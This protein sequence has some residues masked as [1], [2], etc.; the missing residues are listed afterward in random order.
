MKDFT[1]KV[2]R[3]N[4]QASEFVEIAEEL[5]AIQ[6]YSGQAPTS[7]DLT[8][9]WRALAHTHALR[10]RFFFA[11]DLSNATYD[12]RVAV[13]RLAN[14][15]HG[16]IAGNRGP[17]VPGGVIT[18]IKLYH[19]GELVGTAAVDLN[20]TVGA[21]SPGD[22]VSSPPSEEQILAWSLATPANARELAEDARDFDASDTLTVASGDFISV[23]LHRDGGAD[24]YSG[25]W[26][27]YAIELV[28]E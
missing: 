4:L 1:T 25:N 18:G 23:H 2:N 5:K 15:V 24:A 16:Y 9:L 14:G 7:D 27:V 3:E 10:N 12:T 28:W 8:Q 21:Y 26:D 22:S 6:T 20:I 19:Y 17:L 11:N 13:C